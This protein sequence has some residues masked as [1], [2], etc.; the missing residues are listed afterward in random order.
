[1]YRDLAARQP[2]AFQEGLA[3]SVNSLANAL[4]EARQYDRAVEADHEAVRHYRALAAQR[5]EAFAPSHHQCARGE[6][7]YA[8]VMGDS[9]G[10]AAAAK[11]AIGSLRAVFLTDP[12]AFRSVMMN[13]LRAYVNSS[14]AAG[15]E[16][17]M[18]LFGSVAPLLNLRAQESGG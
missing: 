1:L 3:R 15:V 5:P 7:H 11:E 9:A 14:D 6:E 2:D 8:A 13:L 10:S 17:D 4:A 16:V 12:G 18:N